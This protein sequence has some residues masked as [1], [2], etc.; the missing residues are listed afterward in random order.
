LLLLWIY[1]LFSCFLSFFE[2]IFL[3][4]YF[5]FFFPLLW[6]T[7]CSVSRRSMTICMPYWRFC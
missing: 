2:F 5:P 6:F 1:I 3:L 7:E 4:C